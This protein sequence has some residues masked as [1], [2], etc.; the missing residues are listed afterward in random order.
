MKIVIAHTKFQFIKLLRTPAFWAPTILFP[1]MLY[2]FFGS[3]LPPAG[4]PSQMAIASFC[5]YAVVG[6]T[7]YQFGIGIAQDRE[8]PFDSWLKT[9]PGSSA[10]NG[11]AQVFSAIVFAIIA[12]GLVLAASTVLAKTTL[13]A[14]MTTRLIGY[15]LIIAIPASLMGLALGFFASGRAAPALANLIFLP[16]AFL[17]GLWIPPILMPATIEKIS[18]WTPTRQ[19]AEFAWS[20]VSGQVPDTKTFMLFAG[21]TLVFAALVVFLVRR[22]RQKR[23]G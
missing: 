22:D 13:S 18:S 1:A 10:P 23:F 11:M 4:E 12:V 19:M 15:C 21:Y 2:S 14:A 20:A 17:G 16:L 5:V 7:F 9:L 3:S 6:I 8:N